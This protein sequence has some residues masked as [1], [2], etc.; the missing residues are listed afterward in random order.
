MFLEMI[1]AKKLKFGWNT[2]APK[3]DLLEAK[4][5]KTCLI[6][7]PNQTKVDSPRELGDRSPRGGYV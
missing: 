1:N 3:N 6:G 2:T 5:K 4:N 7:K